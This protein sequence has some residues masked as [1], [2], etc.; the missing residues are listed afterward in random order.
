MITKNSKVLL[1]CVCAGL[2]T[3]LSWSPFLLV[4]WV[5]GIKLRFLGSRSKPFYAPSH[6]TSPLEV[7]T[8]CG[9]PCVTAIMW[10][11]EHNCWRSVLYLPPWVLRIQLSKEFHLLSLLSFS[12]APPS[13]YCSWAS[14]SLPSEMEHLKWGGLCPDLAS[15][16]HSVICMGSTNIHFFLSHVILNSLVDLY[17]WF[18][19]PRRG[20]CWDSVSPYSAGWPWTWGG[21]LA[22]ASWVPGLQVSV[23]IRA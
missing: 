19:F 21:P 20:R 16:L 7:V 1:S 5:L 10:R 18:F 13:I 14:V 9:Y 2:R 17:M 22:S 15:C 4:T 12:S 8:V 11:S 3:T 23:I 6:L